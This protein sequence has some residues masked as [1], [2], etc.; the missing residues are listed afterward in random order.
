[1]CVCV[2]V[3]VC[4]YFC[5]FSITKS[6]P[7]LCYPMDCSIPDF[8]VHHYLPEFAHTHYSLCWWWYLTILSSVVLFSFCLQSLPAS[9]SFLVGQ[10][11]LSKWPK[12][13]SF[14]SSPFNEYSGLIYFRIDWFDLTVQKTSKS[15]L[16]HHHSKASVLQWSAFCM[17]QLSYPYMTTGK[18]IALTMDFCPQ[19][20]F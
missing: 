3:C 18:T 7:I 16:Q 6:F 14:N 17:I 2:C 20:A 4:V 9:E 13:W 15:L 1:M 10:H 8:P 11:S 12:Y 5:S 19:S